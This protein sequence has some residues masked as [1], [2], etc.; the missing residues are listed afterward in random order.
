LGVE[1]PIFEPSEP[2]ARQFEGPNAA[3]ILPDTA[4][5]AIAEDPSLIDSESVREANSDFSGFESES[6]A[7]AIP[8]LKW[9]TA[10]WG[11]GIM[12]LLGRSVWNYWNVLRNMPLEQEPAPEW[13]VEWDD[14]L[15]SAGIRFPATLYVTEHM[16]PML[17]RLP[18]EYR[19]IIP[20][21][22]WSRLQAN[23]RAA[24][25]R[26]EIAHLLRGDVWKS[27]AIRILAIPQ[28]F[29]P[30][31][32]WAVRRFDDCAEWACDEA[33]KLADPDHV[34][35][36]ARALLQLG[37]PSKTLI[38][39]SPAASGTGLSRRIR[40]LISANSWEDS[41]MK[42]LV[43][44][45][46]ILGLSSFNVFKV[47]LSAEEANT[48]SAT[49]DVRVSPASAPT[50][51]V[52]DDE[53]TLLANAGAASGH[54]VREA[55]VDI[56][57]LFM[58]FEPFQRDREMLKAEVAKSDESA[59]SLS[60]EIEEI[61]S[62]RKG[63]IAERAKRAHEQGSVKN[64]D[65]AREVQQ[66]EDLGD[67]LVVKRATYSAQR[68][69][70]Q[71]RLSRQEREMHQRA[72]ERISA[73]IAAYAKEHG[74][75]TVR[76]APVSSKDDFTSTADVDVIGRATD[77]PLQAGLKRPT[78]HKNLD[79]RLQAIARLKR[80]ADQKNLDPWNQE[81]IYGEQ[82]EIPVV[83]DITEEILKRLKAN[84]VKPKKEG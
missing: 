40:R 49:P 12:L 44:V 75:Q 63:I 11:A 47:D 74:M 25:L 65:S 50:L 30:L 62:K 15:R 8:W 72:Y 67:Q 79:L 83:P 32:W 56:R 58:N 21:A 17:C 29:N 73:E 38:L 28:W 42:K 43:M 68:T 5:I 41:K 23:Q 19:L 13:V 26:H 4:P 34:A 45:A 3:P 55:T 22:Y 59:R 80:P 39:T 48:P 27:M 81:V 16:G 70:N 46:L 60:R 52:S 10:A 33:A 9:L 71:R 2:V 37:S 51:V 77:G 24:I 82:L 18:G 20:A 36:Y 64:D 69:V 7:F 31:A 6:A 54:V 66:W 35:E 78:D 76:R 57:Y 84:E 53:P 61:E 14:L 1:I